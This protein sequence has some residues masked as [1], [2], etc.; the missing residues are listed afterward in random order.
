MEA[1]FQ[2]LLT[3]YNES[4][5]S[6]SHPFP[7]LIVSTYQLTGKETSTLKLEI[8]EALR[9]SQ[10]FVPISAIFSMK[11]MHIYFNTPLG[12][13]DYRPHRG[14]FSRLV[15]SDYRAPKADRVEP[16]LILKRLEWEKLK[17]YTNSILR[18]PSS[19]LGDA[20]PLSIREP[21]FT[22]CSTD[23]EGMIHQN[24]FLDPGVKHNCLTWL[25]LA[26][27]GENGTRLIDLLG[28]S[29]GPS[30]PQ[31]HSYIVDFYHYLLR[32][33]SQQRVRHLIYWTQKKLS[34]ATREVYEN[35]KF[36]TEF[37]GSE[38][39]QTAKPHTSLESPSTL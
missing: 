39:A 23:T 22:V 24:R 25:T 28:C 13:L 2:K 11:M 26:P 17:N 19:V 14:Q 7:L 18:D 21:D 4:T 31:A 35:P 9:P 15:L 33:A 8:L 3:N 36:L 32:E 1:R 6:V 34:I 16:V 30:S 38:S 27:I 12:V 20:H 29:F 5:L 37:Y 10:Q